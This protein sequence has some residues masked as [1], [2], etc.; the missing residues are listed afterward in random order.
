MTSLLDSLLADTIERLI[1]IANPDRIVQLGRPV[2]GESR[3][4][5]EVLLLIIVPGCFDETRTRWDE[6]KRLRAALPSYPLRCNLVL[7]TAE[8]F[9][10]FRHYPNHLIAEALRD[11]EVVFER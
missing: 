1:R 7:F 3:T 6:A 8:Q 5:E 4:D 10:R 9:D 2:S 11:G